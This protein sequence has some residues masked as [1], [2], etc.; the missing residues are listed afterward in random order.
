[1][2]WKPTKLPFDGDFETKA[3][4]KK[5]S[6]AN[7]ALAE[8]K[9]LAQSIP[10]QDILINTLSLQEAKDSSEVESIVTTNDEL[11]KNALDLKTFQ[12]PAAKEVE[13][14][15]SAMKRGFELIQK[16]R[17][18]TTN[19]IIEIQ[20]ILERNK[21]GLRKIPGTTLTNKKTG[22]IVYDPPQNMA[23]IKDLMQNL[24]V[25]I[26]D[27]ELTDY[28][29]IVKM[30]IIH[31]QFESIHPFYDGNGRTGRIINILYLILNDLL[32][33]PI[34]YLSRY[35]I[36]HK[37]DYYRLLQGVRDHGNWEEW[38]IFMITAVE[39]TAHHTTE[40]VYNI[41]S[42]MSTMK[43][44]LRQ[45]YKFYSQELL[46]HLFRQPYTKIEFLQ[47]DL[48]ISRVTAALY[49]NT[50]AKDNVLQKE[51]LGKTNYYINSYLMETLLP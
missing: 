39:Q 43:T 32:N 9:G 49:L 35:I 10:R 50:L 12:S 16:N 29:P 24:E 3:V 21:A 20:E 22:K 28:D 34:L 15:V 36:N 14:Y 4:L 1:M 13:N 31:F 2:N 42:D 11:Y 19:N 40:L 5:L 18:L 26:N 8:L 23:E 17:I 51:K 25:F 41:K 7:R 27:N 6:T 38:L 47:N 37:Q 30:A 46:N 33:I 44:I 45:N 48:G